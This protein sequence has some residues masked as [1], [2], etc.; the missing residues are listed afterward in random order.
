M[1]SLI[2]KQK[3]GFDSQTQINVSVLDI[4]IFVEHE[5]IHNFDYSMPLSI[6]KHIGF[7]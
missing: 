5:S 1:L 2:H 4:I 7:D 3:L 6:H